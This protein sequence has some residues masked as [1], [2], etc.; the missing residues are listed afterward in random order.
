L[1]A[2][3]I[4]WL[5]QVEVVCEDGNTHMLK[6]SYLRRASL[7]CFS[8][9]AFLPIDKPSCEEWDFLGKLGVTLRAG[10]MFY[11]RRL[12]HLK[13]QVIDGK[14]VE[15][16]YEKIQAYFEDDAESIL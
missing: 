14:E 10:G 9:L 7:E 3:A 6:A 11:V 16:L 8:D 12:V 4:L 5:S 1:A 15:E 13:T 2:S